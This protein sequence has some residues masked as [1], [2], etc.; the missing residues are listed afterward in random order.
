MA[1]YSVLSCNTAG[2]R[3]ED[4]LAV[5]T[6]FALSEQ[7]DFSVFQ[8]THL[9]YTHMQD[10][11]NNWDGEFL[12]SPGQ[13][14]TGGILILQA[15][16]SPAIKDIKSDPKGRYILFRIKDSNDLVAAIYAPSGASKEKQTERTNFYKHFNKILKK[17]IKNKDNILL[18]GDF[19]VTLEKIDRSRDDNFKCSSQKELQ[20]ILTEFDLTDVWRTENP[21]KE[22]YTYSHNSGLNTRIDRAYTTTAL[23]PN[24]NIKHKINSFSDHH[25]SVF[26]KRENKAFERGKGYWIFNN[27][28][29]EE[30]NFIKEIN[31][32]W[33][34][35]QD[36]KPSFDSISEW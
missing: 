30:E 21:Q 23:T 20:N 17:Y 13:T 22:L 18:V 1:G 7:P 19:N 14:Q 4:R 34:Q 27:S 16:N 8:E 10:I 24:I 32:L 12:I 3:G 33:K 2:L 6:N 35:W 26:L 15:Q 9:D 11:K 28:F 25:L 36:Y 5:A 29:L 31:S